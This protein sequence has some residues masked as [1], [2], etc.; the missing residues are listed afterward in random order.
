M[1]I[2]RG[3][4]CACTNISAVSQMLC[5]ANHESTLSDSIHVC[6]CILTPFVYSL[7]HTV[8]VYLNIW[9]MAF[10]FLLMINTL[11]LSPPTDN[12]FLGTE[13]VSS[14]WLFKATT[15]TVLMLSDPPFVKLPLSLQKLSLSLYNYSNAVSCKK[16]ICSHIV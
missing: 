14:I 15:L 3:T 11:F 1:R 9:Y 5:H 10:L 8:S 7:C 12:H 6:N 13:K 16:I 4:K 2:E